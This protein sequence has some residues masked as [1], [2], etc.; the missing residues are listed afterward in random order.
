V[1]TS[2]HLRAKIVR[3]TIERGREGLLYAESPDLKGLMVAR[4]TIEELRRQI[5]IAI[6]AMFAADDVSVAVSEVE[7]DDDCSWV[8]VPIEALALAHS[9]ACS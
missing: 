8:A 2:S 5:P 3:V 4:Q 7:S 1:I 9:E 6:Q